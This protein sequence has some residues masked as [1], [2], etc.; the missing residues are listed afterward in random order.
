MFHTFSSR[1]ADVSS[2]SAATIAR[3]TP[4]VGFEFHVNRDFG[5]F[6]SKKVNVLAVPR[7]ELRSVS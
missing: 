6:G 7:C 1:G 2:I 3:A 5:L 4:Y